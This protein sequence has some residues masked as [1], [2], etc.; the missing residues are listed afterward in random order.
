[1]LS[2][3]LKFIATRSL[4]TKLISS[5][6][7]IAILT[8]A[9]IYLIGLGYVNA[10]WLNS[11]INATN[12]GPV[13]GTIAT[14]WIIFPFIIGALYLLVGIGRFIYEKQKGIQKGKTWKTKSMIMKGLGAILISILLFLFFSIAL[15]FIGSGLGPSLPKL[16]PTD[17]QNGT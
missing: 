2:K 15:G 4:F 12:T 17:I 13:L 1:M 6:T 16:P 10:S 7:I 8:I 3:L 11:L 9:L 14:I 5:S